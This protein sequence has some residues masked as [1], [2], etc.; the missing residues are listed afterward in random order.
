M[1]SQIITVIILKKSVRWEISVARKTLRFLV[2]SHRLPFF[3]T[4]QAPISEKPL[5]TNAHNLIMEHWAA[6][7]PLQGD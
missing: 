2:H 4:Q 1:N 7:K 3:Q 5:L 6:K